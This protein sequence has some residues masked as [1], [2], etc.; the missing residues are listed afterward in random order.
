MPTR[1]YWYAPTDVNDNNNPQAAFEN[2]PDMRRWDVS[3]RQRHDVDFTLAA[4]PIAMHGLPL[5]TCGCGRLGCIETYLSAP[6]LSRIAAHLAGTG[7]APET[8]VADRA[9]NRHFA[10]AW[11]IW[12]D[13][14]TEFLVTLCMTLD[15]QVIVL[16]GG[17]SRLGRGIRKAGR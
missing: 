11:E 15:P 3:D 13:L 10:R 6:G 8:I 7:H 2:H 9:R 4:A 12:L 14:A 16:G 17:L 1:S 5:L